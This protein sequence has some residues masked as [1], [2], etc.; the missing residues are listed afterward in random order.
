MTLKG[1][2]TG[3]NSLSNRAAVLLLMCC[4]LVILCIGCNRRPSSYQV[5]RVASPNGNLE[6]VLTETN[7]GAT[8]SFG[9]DVTVGVKGTRNAEKVASLY[10]AIRNEQAYG[11]NLS[12]ADNHVLRI[13][14][15]RAKSVQDVRKTVDLNGQQVE[16]VLQSG[17]VDITAPAGGM[18]FTLQKQ[19]H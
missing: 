11:V 16:V 3:G 15:L 19:P 6:A 14:Y 10:G 9:Y 18:Q 12:W 7:G 1:I 17:I 4:P 2:I 8:T 13:Q 5:A